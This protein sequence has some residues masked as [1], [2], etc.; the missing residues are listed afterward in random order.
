MRLPKNFQPVGVSKRA[1]FFA[2][3]TRST[4]PDAGMDLATAL[5]PPCAAKKGMQSA[6]AARIA[7]ESD[8]V[9]KNWCLRQGRWRCASGRR[10]RC[11][12][13]QR[14]RGDMKTQ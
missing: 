6:C 11:V 4:A 3:A 7:N 9:T 14:R 2:W 10:E 5:I 12:S 8:G 1:K 13:R